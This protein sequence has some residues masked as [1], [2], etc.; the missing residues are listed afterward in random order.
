MRD[1]LINEQTTGIYISG[2]KWAAED[3]MINDL[4]SKPEW[5]LFCQFLSSFFC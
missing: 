3:E 5:P 2:N 4:E 1:P